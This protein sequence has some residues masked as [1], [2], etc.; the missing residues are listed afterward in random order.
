VIKI[1]VPF[2]AKIWRSSN[3]YV[4]TIPKSYID[5]FFLL[6][7]DQIFLKLIVPDNFN[8]ILPFEKEVGEDE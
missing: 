7:G 4:V 2:R 1:E 3:S 8:P 6:E 5:N